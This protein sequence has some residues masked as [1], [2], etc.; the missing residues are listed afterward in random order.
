MASFRSLKFGIDELDLIFRNGALVG[1]D[2]KNGAFID[3]VLSFKIG[4]WL[5]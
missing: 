3:L 4:C 5:S 1:L 2:L